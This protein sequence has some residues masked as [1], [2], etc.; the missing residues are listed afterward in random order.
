MKS[1]NTENA[2][3]SRTNDTSLDSRYGAI[4]IPAVAAAVQYQTE[5]KAPAPA[6]VILPPEGDWFAD[7]AA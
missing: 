3:R 2:Q 5:A 4:G 7:L 6:P 1:T